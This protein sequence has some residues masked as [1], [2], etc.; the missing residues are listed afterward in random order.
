MCIW[1]IIEWI[2]ETWF[3]FHNLDS[4]VCKCRKWN[5]MRDRER[6]KKKKAEM[7]KV[8]Q[9]DEMVNCDSISL[10]NM[11]CVM[12]SFSR[13]LLTKVNTHTLTQTLFKYLIWQF[14]HHDG[15][16]LILF[17]KMTKDVTKLKMK[18]SDR[19]KKKHGQANDEEAHW[20]RWRTENCEFIGAFVC[21]TQFH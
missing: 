9:N 20:I 2:L 18:M 4:H 3:P 1:M 21:C 12:K 10:R 17:S 14:L 7:T 8:L 19:R 6:V 16:L 13:S 5:I 11:K 15:S